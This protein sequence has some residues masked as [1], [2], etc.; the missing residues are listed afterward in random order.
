MFQSLE[1]DSV[2]SSLTW[3]RRPSWIWCSFNLLSEILFVQANPAAAN[4]PNP[5]KGFNLL[6][7][8]LFVQAPRRRV[9]GMDT[10][11]FQSLERDS[12]CSSYLDT[13]TSLTVLQFQSLERDSVC[14]SWCGF[15]G[16]VEIL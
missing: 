16:M 13:D 4:A 9:R 15:T 8:I 12:V 10:S 5:L 1:R 2:C 3:R 11:V 6:S 7:E 14:S